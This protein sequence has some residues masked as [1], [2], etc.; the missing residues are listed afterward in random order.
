MYTLADHE[1]IYIYGIKHKLEKSA[2]GEN[3]TS[4][5]ACFS[6]GAIYILGYI[7]TQESLVASTSHVS[8]TN[9]VKQM[10][11]F[12]EKTKTLAK[13]K[14]TQVVSFTTE[15]CPECI[16]H[17]VPHNTGNTTKISEN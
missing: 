16:F 17:H 15:D 13:P 12:S 10:N 8:Y 2:L 14:F 9:S 6:L 5:K 11:N 3:P 4:T 1:V 7:S